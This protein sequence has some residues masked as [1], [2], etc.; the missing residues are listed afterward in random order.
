MCDVSSQQY[1]I[2]RIKNILNIDKAHIGYEN[3]CACLL[4]SPHVRIQLYYHFREIGKLNLSQAPHC[5]ANVECVSCNKIW[6]LMDRFPAL[7][8]RGFIIHNVIIL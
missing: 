6:P 7:S 3:N 5:S 2:S 8:S 1:N 4:L